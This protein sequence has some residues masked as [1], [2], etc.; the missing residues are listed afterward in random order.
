MAKQRGRKANLSPRVPATRKLPK[1]G[2]WVVKELPD[3]TKRRVFVPQDF[4]TPA[5][6]KALEAAGWNRPVSKHISDAAEETIEAADFDELIARLDH[7]KGAAAEEAVM[8]T[9]FDEITAL[10]DLNND[11]RHLVADYISDARYQQLPKEFRREVKPFHTALKQVVARF[12]RC[13]TTFAEA[14]NL[15]LE[16][17]D[18][19][20]A[21]DG[22]VCRSVV[23][24]L[25]QASESILADEAGRGTDA[26]RAKRLFFDGL[27]RIYK[28]RTG[29]KPTWVF[30]TKEEKPTGPF[31]TFAAAVNKQL[32]ADVRLTDINHLIRLYLEEIAAR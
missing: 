4:A 3:G 22:D 16:K 32:P 6:V 14:L 28:E 1:L 13:G 2:K 25:F 31:F 12:P 26:N 19:E 23:F 8:A 10:H 17:L 29:L 11:I 21:P 9:A 27:A 18:L 7:S 30:D 24:A 5:V 15:E 20:D